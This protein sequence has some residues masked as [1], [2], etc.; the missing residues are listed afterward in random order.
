MVAG[1]RPEG[2]MSSTSS[3]GNPIA[4][5]KARFGANDFHSSGRLYLHGK[6]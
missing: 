5:D 4:P 6:E 1:R 2:L 3:V